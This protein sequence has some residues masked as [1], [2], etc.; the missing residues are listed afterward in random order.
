MNE[1]HAASQLILQIHDKIV[2]LDDLGDKPKSIIMEKLAVGTRFI[3]VTLNIQIN[4]ASPVQTDP[5][6][7]L[8]RKAN[9]SMIRVQ[10]FL[11]GVSICIQL[12]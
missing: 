7:P 8:R 6:D 2:E 4:S 10:I 1:G 11:W 3:I 5:K 9:I 12:I